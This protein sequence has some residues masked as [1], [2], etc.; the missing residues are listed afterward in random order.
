[1]PKIHTR[2][3]ENNS[4][5]YQQI[6]EEIAV[7]VNP[8]LNKGKVA[9]YIPA[10]AEVDPNNFAMSIAT[11]DGQL[12][13][14]GRSNTKFSIQSISKVYS[15]VAAFSALGTEIWNRIGKEPS[16]TPFNSL[17]QLE[18]ECGIPRNPFIN[19]GAMVITDMLLSIYDHPKND[20]LDFVNALAGQNDIGIDKTVAQSE[21]KYGFKNAALVNFL[22]S[23]DNIDNE[24]EEVLD[25]YF[26]HCAITMNTEELAKSFLF[27]ANG[28]VNPHN[29]QV[30]LNHSQTKRLNA[31]MLTCGTYDEAGEFAFRVGMPGKSG[32]GG[33]IVAVIPGTLAAS[34]WSP[35]LN[36]KGNSLAGVQALELFTTK[37]KM[38]VF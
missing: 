33:G 30:I 6:L 7:E 34:V 28:G 27:L 32:V 37:T 31:L 23:H 16:G 21:K 2:S 26:C 22:K 5:N 3:I 29:G 9:D 35:G 12:Y 18:Q 10:L 36:Q 20:L 8:L 11:L 15:L 19:A 17:I 25:L 13:N 4:M 38:S 14:V 24:I 1:M